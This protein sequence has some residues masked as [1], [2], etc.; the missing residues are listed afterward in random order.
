MVIPIC[1]V[2]EKLLIKNLLFVLGLVNTVWRADDDAVVVFHV[3]EERLEGQMFGI[4]VTA[5]LA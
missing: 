2:Y 4:G 5:L 3:G 1:Q